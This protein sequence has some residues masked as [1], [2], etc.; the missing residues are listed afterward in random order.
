SLPPG[1]SSAPG[2]S[3]ALPAAAS[4]PVPAV[5]APPASPC[6]FSPRSR[7]PQQSPQPEGSAPARILPEGSARSCACAA[8][9]PLCAVRFCAASRDPVAADQ[10]F[11]ASDSCLPSYPPIL[12]PSKFCNHNVT[13]T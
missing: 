1:Q 6:C 13:I 8:A 10:F 2:F 11:F 3:A 4:L 5:P 9:S 7:S 12:L